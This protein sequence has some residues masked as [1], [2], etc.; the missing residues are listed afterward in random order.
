MPACPVETLKA[1]F[2]GASPLGLEALETDSHPY[3]A[4]LPSD[5][6]PMEVPVGFAPT[7]GGF[8]DHCVSYFA[9]V[10]S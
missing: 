5:P 7:N 8:A 10:P 1:Y 9:T 6:A 3:I 2:T 4:V